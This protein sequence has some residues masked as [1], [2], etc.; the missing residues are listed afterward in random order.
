MPRR[1]HPFYG[2]AIVAGAFVSHFL[3]Y[4][5]L[6]VAFGIFFPFMAEALG[7]GRG[8]LASAGV[9]TRLVSAGAA[10]FVGPLVDRHGPRLFTALG[11]ASL[12]AGA[13]VLGSARNAGHV[14]LGYG[15]VM[16]VAS[17]ALGELSGDAT[18][19]RWFVRRRARALAVATMGLS[20]AGIVIP[21]PLAWLITHVGWRR[22]W[23]VLGVAVLGLGLLAAA[24]MR[25]R[26]E[27][28]GLVP[29]GDTGGVSV[30]AARARE[31]S[32]TARQ[33]AR[34][35]AFWLLVTGTNLAGLALFGVNLHRFSYVRDKGL[36]VGPAAAVVTYLYVLHTVAKPVSATAWPRATWAAPSA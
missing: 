18:V 28:L 14:F 27:D 21:L 19:T 11:V 3:S 12:A 2:W 34:T 1:R 10:P 7:L 31:V 26:P 15:L 16:A 13:A 8:V 35:P 25:R 29:D 20:A 22:A 6:T 5:T 9:V 32:L 24:V 33:A 30:A 17:V 4:G 23:M 36:A